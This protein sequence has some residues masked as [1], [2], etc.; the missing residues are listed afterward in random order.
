VT[1]VPAHSASRTP[2]PTPGGLLDEPVE[3]FVNDV[4]EVGEKAIDRVSRRRS[5]EATAEPD[6][7][8]VQFSCNRTDTV[9]AL[10]TSSPR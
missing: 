1:T 2:S 4:F 7:G 5:I 9:D 10:L 3:D 8:V 6:N